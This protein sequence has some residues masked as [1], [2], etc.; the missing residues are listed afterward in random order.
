[1]NGVSDTSYH[2]CFLA[3]G[4]CSDD[5]GTGEVG[6]IINFS[7]AN[8]VCTGNHEPYPIT[9]SAT[10]E[11]DATHSGST[12]L[13]AS[14]AVLDSPYPQPEYQTNGTIIGVTPDGTDV[15]VYLQNLGAVQPNGTTPTNLNSPNF[16]SA[17]MQGTGDPMVRLCIAKSTAPTTVME[18]WAGRWVY[19][20]DRTVTNSSVCG[21][22]PVSASASTPIA[23][24]IPMRHGFFGS[25]WVRPL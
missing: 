6:L 17:Q 11:G 5:F 13:T 3:S 14:I 25:R 19:S 18:Y 20:A 1:M 15:A 8:S 23:I 4:S 7:C 12:S 9:V 2:Y 10:Y 22:V 21:E 24:G 16:Y